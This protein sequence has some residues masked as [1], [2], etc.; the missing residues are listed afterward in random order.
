M[1]FPVWLSVYVKVFSFQTVT[2]MLAL[3]PGL[4]GFWVRRSFYYMTLNNAP[5]DISVGFGSQIWGRDVRLGA[6]VYIGGWT[7]I[8]DCIIG[9]GTLIGSHVDIFSGAHQ[10]GGLESLTE[11][12][13]DLPMERPET[14]V[15]IGENAWVGDGVTLFANVGDN[16]IVGAGSVVVKPIPANCIAAGNPARVLKTL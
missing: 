14:L 4:M 6:N 13:S 16:T 3:V 10:H 11:N 9:K 8:N 5:T 15:T 1:A 7:T 2:E 12:K